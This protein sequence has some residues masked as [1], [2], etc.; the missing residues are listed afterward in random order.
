MKNLIWLFFLTPCIGLHGQENSTLSKLEK[1]YK[2]FMTACDDRNGEKALKYMD[3]NS[4]VFFELMLND[5]WYADSVTL[6]KLP[7][8]EKHIIL[9]M[10]QSVPYEK[11]VS[12]T[13]HSFAIYVLDEIGPP[14]SYAREG[15]SLVDFRKENSKAYARLI[16]R[17]FHLDPEFE[18][19][20]EKGRWKLSLIP[21]IQDTES[22]LP[23]RWKKRDTTEKDFIVFLVESYSDMPMSPEIWNPVKN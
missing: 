14:G 5:L 8:A 3:H 16:M 22:R 6:E 23:A 10:R 9:I 19:T 21:F 20:K 1:T 4:K 7:I 2:G 12:F 15:Y 11:L 18:F 17:E 13:P